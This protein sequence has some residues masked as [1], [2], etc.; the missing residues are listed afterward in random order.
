MLMPVELRK[1]IKETSRE[2]GV[3]ESVFVREVLK[4]IMN[5]SKSNEQSK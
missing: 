4:T 5:R 1:F 3:A 2:M